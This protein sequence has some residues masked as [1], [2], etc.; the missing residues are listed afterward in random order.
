MKQLYFQLDE[1]WVS[2]AEEKE[3]ILQASLKAGIPHTHV[4]G[5]HARCSTCRVMI[6]E[7]LEHCNPRNRREQ[8]MADKLHF[9]PNIRLACQTTVR[10]NVRL[11]R[12]VRD[13]QDLALA[14]Q[15]GGQGL[16]AVGVEQSIVILFSDLK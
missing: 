3:T 11:R 12:L 6:L 16:G 2:I 10:D 13:R 4:C 5:G 15:L 14:N 1:K 7:G 9:S 8:L